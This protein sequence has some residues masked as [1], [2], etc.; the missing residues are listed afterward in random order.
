[1]AVNVFKTPPVL[2]ERTVRAATGI[3]TLDGLRVQRGHKL[4][5]LRSQSGEG[6]AMVEGEL[7]SGT[8]QQSPLNP[9]VINSLTL[10]HTLFIHPTRQDLRDAYPP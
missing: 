5:D 3:V 10:I 6:G 1:M 4:Y 2:R 9:I 8:Q 7:D